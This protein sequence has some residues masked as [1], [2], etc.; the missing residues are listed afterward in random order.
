MFTDNFLTVCDFINSNN[1]LIHTPVNHFESIHTQSP[2]FKVPRHPYAKFDMN[3]QLGVSK[4]KDM[5][6]TKIS[7]PVCLHHNCMRDVFFNILDPLFNKDSPFDSQTLFMTALNKH[8]HLLKT[9]TTKHKQL[10]K[11]LFDNATEKY[12]RSF[13]ETFQNPHYMQF[14]KELLRSN[15]FVIH[16]NQKTFSEYIYEENSEESEREP[17]TLC[18]KVEKSSTH[19]VFS[20]LDL[21]NIDDFRRYC[22]EYSIVQYHDTKTLQ[23]MKINQLKDICRELNINDSLNKKDSI[24]SIVRKFV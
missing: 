4:A 13:D 20:L 12:D 24:E 10:H 16:P 9:L 22:R 6:T 8:C 19:Y 14:W 2:V 5:G 15:I 21:K 18:I 23:K 11:T 1:N 17:I 7:A 3:R